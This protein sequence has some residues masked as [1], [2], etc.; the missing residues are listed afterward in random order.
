MLSFSS[1]AKATEMVPCKVGVVSLVVKAVT[2]GSTVG[3]V[4]SIVNS[5]VVASLVLKPRALVTVAVTG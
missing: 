4:V 5:P 3:A 2:A 1:A